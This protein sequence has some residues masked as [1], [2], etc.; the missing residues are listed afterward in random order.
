MWR[1]IFVHALMAEVIITL[2]HASPENL[3]AA[4]ILLF[5]SITE[6]EAK[7]ELPNG[8]TAMWIQRMS[9]W[10]GYSN[11]IIIKLL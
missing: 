1:Y 4:Q 9:I 6:N 7:V 5:T 2:F 11:I 10:T 8:L 3:V